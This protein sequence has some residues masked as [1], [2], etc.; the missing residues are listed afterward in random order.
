MEPDSRSPAPYLTSQLAHVEARSRTLD[1][2][3]D[4]IKAR[5][6]IYAPGL[7]T[8]GIDSWVA[9]CGYGKAA[10]LTSGPLVSQQQTGDR[11]H[12]R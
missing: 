10:E 4:L 7:G 6:L 11:R 8:I 12:Y 5:D 1:N 3:Q 9:G 2:Y